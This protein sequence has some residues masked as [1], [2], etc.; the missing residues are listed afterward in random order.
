M[1]GTADF[2]IDRNERT[3]ARP[4]R[5]AGRIPPHNL[6]AEES[7]LGSLLLSRDAIGRVGEAGLKVRVF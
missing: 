2:S 5:P 4:Q 7:V 6:Q 3:A 1:A